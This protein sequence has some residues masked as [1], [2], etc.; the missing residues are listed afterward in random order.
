MRKTLFL[1][2]ATLLSGASALAQGSP[3]PVAQR[4]VPVDTL[5]QQ[6]DTLYEID[7]EALLQALQRLAAQQ[8]V[9]P[10]PA[11][12]LDADQLLRYQMLI[13]LLTAQRAPAPMPSVLPSVQS[14]PSA[15]LRSSTV[16]EYTTE[17]ETNARRKESRS[18]R[19]A[20]PTVVHTEQRVVPARNGLEAAAP[21]LDIAGTAALL[22]SLQKSSNETAQRL[23]RIEAQQ[24]ALLV[25][26]SKTVA[27]SDSLA[28]DSAQ[29]LLGKE[30][31]LPIVSTGKLG[32]PDA[33]VMVLPADFKR[34]VFFQIGSHRLTAQ[35][36]KEL[37]EAVRFLERFPT[38]QLGIAGYAS[39]EGSKAR[40]L[41]LSQA[42]LQAV[43]E[44]LQAKGVDA[45]RLV[46]PLESKI[47]RV[48]LQPIARRVDLFL[49]QP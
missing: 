9:A 15:E 45:S 48:S 12:R 37:D 10:P 13:Q 18:R 44:Y 36:C 21:L 1:L 14:H 2:F 47:D 42:R 20:S 46:Q 29:G 6:G 34:S 7:R 39:P 4:L 24:Q 26:L 32:T 40:N 19:Q 8:S 43:R 31:G 16:R 22:A 41:Y 38:V 35:A 11:A 33:K 23:S 49:L 17:V 30:S 27:V 5:V 3:S 28:T 25:R